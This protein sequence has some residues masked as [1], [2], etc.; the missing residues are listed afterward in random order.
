[1]WKYSAV[2]SVVLSTKSVGMKPQMQH[3][4][5][6]AALKGQVPQSCLLRER[7]PAGRR[8]LV[9]LP[10]REA[11]QRSQHQRLHI[12]RGGKEA[13]WKSERLKASKPNFISTAALR[14]SIYCS[15][16]SVSREETMPCSWCVFFSLSLLSLENI[17]RQVEGKNFGGQLINGQRSQFYS[18]LSFGW[19]TS[20]KPWEL[21]A[22]QVLFFNGSE[23]IL[24]CVFRNCCG[25]YPASRGRDAAS[26]QASQ[27]SCLLRGL[28]KKGFL[29]AFVH[30]RSLMPTVLWFI[31]IIYFKIR[32]WF[33]LISPSFVS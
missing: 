19:M 12:C 9:P 20:P 23:A 10:Q 7:G 6:R 31:Y 17:Y 28:G 1:M 32:D 29:R 26:L 4:R 5:E 27:H 22:G 15:H 16:S 2:D 3:L 18:L 21:A 30:S 33:R 11:H 14:S 13:I 25:P 8:G 24:F